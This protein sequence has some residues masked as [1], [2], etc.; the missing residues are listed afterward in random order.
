MQYMLLI[1]S[2]SPTSNRSPQEFQTGMQA[3]RSLMEETTRRGILVSAN[4]LRPSETA[5]TVR[6]EPSGKQTITDGP[7][8]ETK[9]QLAGYY[10]LECKDMD[11][12]LA[13]AARIPTS[14][15]A[16]GAR[17]V[18]VRPLLPFAEIQQYFETLCAEQ[19]A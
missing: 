11:E 19:G 7:F 18:E 1:Y 13:Y 9:E 15:A 6:T 17:G 10:L 16:G 3:H 12:A 2:E 4:P 14:C 8:T 5:K